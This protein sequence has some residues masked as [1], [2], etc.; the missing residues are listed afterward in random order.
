MSLLGLDSC[1]CSSSDC[2]HPPAA[3][4][5][6]G[7]AGA[8]DFIAT[9]ELVASVRQVAS[10]Q[11]LQPFVGTLLAFAVLGE[12]PSVW[13]LG[14]VGVLVGLVLVV[15]DKHDLQASI[16]FHATISAVGHARIVRSC[17]YVAWEYA[18]ANIL[19]RSVAA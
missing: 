19:F 10:F 1:L 5:T 15:S 3:A 11:C 9:R 12:E 18:D 7:V 8:Q 17:S 14:A 2:L 4:R 13:D 16:T 6:G